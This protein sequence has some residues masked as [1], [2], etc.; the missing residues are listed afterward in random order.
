MAR[1]PILEEIYAALM[2][3]PTEGTAGARRSS[4]LTDAARNGV[5]EEEVRS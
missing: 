4:V 2:C 5:V 3:H 1:N